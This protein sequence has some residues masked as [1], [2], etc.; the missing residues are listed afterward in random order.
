MTTDSSG[1]RAC[2][3]PILN[4]HSNERHN[5]R[6]REI[7]LLPRA[8]LIEFCEN[9]AVQLLSLFQTGWA[10]VLNV[11]TGSESPVFG[12][13]S[14]DGRSWTCCMTLFSGESLVNILK[15]AS[16]PDAAIETQSAETFNTAVVHKNTE[17]GSNVQLALEVDL[18]GTT[19]S[20]AFS[21][22]TMSNEQAASVAAT[23]AQAIEEIVKN[24]HSKPTELDLFSQHDRNVLSGWNTDIPERLDARVDE[25]IF[26]QGH[27]DP[28]HVAVSSWDGELTYGE[29]ERLSSSLA[30]HLAKQGVRS[31]MF[32]PLCFEKSKWTVVAML[33]VIKAGGAYVLLDPSYP[34]KRMESI[35]QD[36]DATVLVASPQTIDRAEALVDNIVVVDE[37]S[38][39][40]SGNHDWSRQGDSQDALYAAFTSGSTGRPKGIVVEHGAFCTRAL[41]NGAL[42]GL[43]KHSRVL[44]FASYAF[45]VSHR[46]ILF[47]LIH[48]GTVCIPSETDRVNNLEL[49]VNRHQVNW[50]SITPSVAGLL[51]PKAIPTLQTLV[52][53]GEAMTSAHLS[54]WAEKVQLMNAY[55]PSEC[56]AISCINPRLTRGSERTNI[57]RGVGAAIWIVDPEDANRLVPIGAI[58]ELVIETAAVSRGYL[59]NP[60]NTEASF[61]DHVRWRDDFQ[62]SSQ[63]Q[64]YKTGDLGRFNVDGT[65]SFMGRKDSQVKING[66]RVE[67]AEIEHHMLQALAKSLEDSSTIQVVVDMVTPKA[68]HRPTL[69]AFVYQ[70][71]NEQ[72][73]EPQRNTAIRQT[74]AHMAD[75]LAELLPAYMIPSA[76]I[77][78]ERIP[79]TGT[80]KTDRRTLR[81]L[82]ASMTWDQMAS[83][84]ASAPSYR[85]PATEREVQLQRIFMAVLDLEA[86]RVGAD[87]SFL[88]LGGDSIA[89]MRLVAAARREELHLTVADVFRNPRLNEL[90]QLAQTASEPEENIVLP[91][92][93]LKIGISTSD[94][95]REAAS[96][97][98]IQEGQVEDVLPCTPLQEGLLALTA[99]KDSLYI[100]RFKFEIRPTVDIS[101]LMRSWE[102]T[103]AAVPL[104][105]TR[106]AD[107]TGQGLVQVVVNEPVNWQSSPDSQTMG[108]G[109]PLTR[110]E[111]F[112]EQGK[113]YLAL[114]I[115]HAMYDGWSMPLVLDTTQ[116]I[117]RGQQHSLAPFAA[118]IKHIASIDEDAATKFWRRQFV[119]V[120]FSQFPA[121]PL[122][123]ESQADRTLTHSIDINWEGEDFTAATMT[124]AALAI[125][126]SR[127]TNCPD[128]VFG[129]TVMGRHAAVPGVESMA[130]PTFATLP[131]RVIVDEEQTVHQLL[132]QVHTQAT[133][134][135]PY[136]QIGLQHIHRISEESKEACRF[137]TLLL[138]QPG[139]EDISQGSELFFPEEEEQA[140]DTRLGAFTSYALMFRCE[141][142]K[143]GMRLRTTFDSSVVHERQTMRIAHHFAHVLQQICVSAAR[144]TSVS[145]I[146]MATQQDLSD[147]WT[148]NS[149]PPRQV[150]G[151]WDGILPGRLDDHL[152]QLA[153][154]IPWVIQEHAESRLAAVGCVGELWLEIPV[155]GEGH[156][157]KSTASF[158][159]NPHWLLRGGPKQSGRNGRLY[160]SGEL[161]KYT[162]D[163]AVVVLGR[164]DTQPR[165]NGRRVSLRDVEYNVRQ[166]AFEVFHNS[167]VDVIAEI[168]TPQGSQ[169]SMLVAFL[170]NSADLVLT[171]S[172][173]NTIDEELSDRLPVKP[174]AYGILK[175]ETGQINR[176]SFRE[177]VKCFTLAHLTV[178]ERRDQDRARPRTET[179]C[180]LRDLWASV[181]EVPAERIRLNDS[182][183]RLGGDSI[184]AMRLVGAARR[185]GVSLTVEE[186][187][188][189]PQLERLATV[190]KA[191]SAADQAVP[192][193]SLLNLPLNID[194]KRAQTAAL[195]GVESSRVQ[196]AFPCTQLQAGLLALTAQSPGDYIARKVLQLGETTDVNRLTM[197]WAEVVASTPMLR[198]RI[199]DLEN[200]GLVQV[201]VNE[202]F[203]WRTE[204]NL[205][206]YIRADSEEP[207]GLGTPLTR[208]GLVECGMQKYCIL[209]VHHA[210]YDGWLIS[211]LLQAVQKAYHGQPRMA[212]TPFQT[213][214]KA[215]NSVDEASTADFWKS[216]LD[217]LEAPIFPA[218][219]ALSPRTD[220]YATHCIE[221]L[222]VDSG[223]TTVSMAIRAAWAILSAQYVNAT[224]AL[225]GA[226]VTGRQCSVPGIELVGGPTIATVPV[227]VAVDGESTVEQLLQQVQA[228]AVHMIPFEQSGLQR[229][230]RVSADADQAC[231]F[232]TLLVVH[233][234]D[235][236]DQ[237]ETLFIPAQETTGLG[238]VDPYA[239]VLECKLLK[240]GV[241]VQINHDSR[242]IEKGQVER[243]LLQFDHVLRQVCAGHQTTKVRDVGMLSE[244]DLHDIWKWN[245]HIPR[246][247]GV[248]VN[249][250]ITDRTQ[251]QREAPAID[252]WDGRFTYGQLDE[253]STRLAHR[254]RLLGVSTEIFVPLLLEKSR[255]TPVAMLGV[256]KAGG[257]FVL[258]EPNH[259]LTRLQDIC[260][261]VNAH[262]VV[263]SPA[264]AAKAAKLGTTVVT[265]GD[266]QDIG[267]DGG[268]LTTTTTPKNTLY[269]IFTSGS[270]GKPKGAL[271]HHD[272]FASNA[273]AYNEKVGLGSDLRILQFS[274]HAFDVCIS[275][276][277]FT[278]IGGGC[279]CIPSS[280][281]SKDDLSGAIRQFNAN[282]VDLTPSVMR[283]LSPSDV[284]TLTTVSYSGEAASKTDIL[285]WCD[286]VRLINVYGPSE[287]SVFATVQ[288]HITADSDPL[289]IGSPLAGVCWVVNPADSNRLVSV[290]AVGELLLEG[291]PVGKGYL[292]NADK[293]AEAFLDDPSWLVQGYGDQPGRHGR[294]YKTG[295][296]VRYASDGTLQFLGRKDT[297][298]KLRGQRIELGEVEHH[299]DQVLTAI[300]HQ[301]QF[302]EDAAV[303][304][305][306]EIIRPQET[307]RPTLVAFV[308][309]HNSGLP[310]G[311]SIARLDRMVADLDVQ[312]A[313]RLPAYMVPS[314]Y[315]P[316]ESIPL[317]TTGKTDRR[318]LREIG[319]LNHG[320]IA[321]QRQGGKRIAPSTEMESLL[322]EVWMD[323]L[324]LP[325]ETIS[326]D[327]AWIRLGGDSITAM[328]VA[329]RCRARNI[330]L[331]AGD[332]LRAQTIQRLAR[333]C[334]LIQQ[335]APV[336]NTQTIEEEPWGLTPAQHLFFETHPDGLNHFNQ[337]FLLRIKTPVLTDAIRAA[338]HALA[339]R[340]PM[341]RARFQKSRG[342]YWQQYVA[343]YRADV[344]AFAAH[345]VEKAAVASLAQSRQ[346]QLDIQHGPVFA[347]DVFCLPSGEQILLVSAHHLVIDLVSWRVIWHDIE[348][349]LGRRDAVMRPTPSFQAWCKMQSQMAQSLM[350]SQVLPFAVD[351]R[352][353]EYWGVDVAQ[354]IEAES[355]T[356][357]IHLE[358]DVTTRLLGP[359]NERLGTEPT[360][361][362][363]A[364]LFHSFQQ[365]FAD[366]RPPPIFVEGHG[367]E[368]LEGFEVDLSEIV[369][370]F[371]TIFPVYIQPGP[372]DT[373][374]DMIKL[375]KDVR[376]SVPG[377]GLPYTA[378]R[379]LTPAGQTAFGEHRKVE[380][381]FNYVGTY[382][383]LESANSLLSRETDPV[384]TG[385]FS[386]TSPTARRVGLV[387]LNLGTQFGR[388]NI[389]CS[390]HRQMKHQARLQKWMKVFA[391]SL[392]QAA[393]ELTT[394]PKSF[395]LSDFPLLSLSQIGLDSLEKTMQA[396]GISHN[397]VED[398]YPCTPM[399]EGILLSMQKGTASYMT[400]SVR[401]CQ[402]LPGKVPVSP[403]RLE[404]AW[405]DV[406]KRHSILSTVFVPLFENGLF[407]QVLV[408]NAPVRVN[409]ISC[410]SGDPADTLMECAKPVFADGEPQ[411]Q[412]TIC[413]SSNGDVACRL[414]MNHAL[415][416]AESE[417]IIT[418]DLAKAYEGVARSAA[419]R[420]R[421][422]MHHLAHTP[423]ANRMEYW[424][425]ALIN[426]SP[427]R[428]PV[429]RIST[430][431]FPGE[432]G[433]IPL[434]KTATSRIHAFCVNRGI[435]RSVFIQISWAIALSWYTGIDDVC[436]G[437]MAS[438]RDVPIHNIENMV[439]PL[440]NLLISR[441]DVG[442]PLDEVIQKTAESSVEHL[443]HQ[444]VSLAQIQHE[445]KLGHEPLFNSCVTFPVAVNT[446]LEGTATQVTFGYR[447]DL[448]SSSMARDIS[449]MLTMA[450][451]HIL[452][453][454][455]LTNGTS[456][457]FNHVDSL[458]TG[459]F[460]SV[461]GANQQLATDFWQQYFANLDTQHFPSLPSPYYSP[462]ATSTLIYRLLDFQWNR[463]E[464]A[465]STAIRVAWAALLARYTNTSDVVLG[466]LT[467]HGNTNLGTAPV[468][469][470]LDGE[471]TLRQ[472]LEHIQ[473]QTIAMAE[474]ERMGLHNIQRVSDE[475]EQGCQ[476]QTLLVEAACEDG[477]IPNG[478]DAFGLIVQCLSDEEGLHIQAKFD[479]NMIEEAHVERMMRQF[480]HILRQ[481]YAEGNQLVKVKDI[482]W[483]CEEDMRDIW[484][485]NRSVPESVEACM[486]DQIAEMAR[487]QPEALAI[488]AWD[489]ELTYRELD[490]LSTRLA[491]HLMQYVDSDA[492]VPL[493]FEKSVWT[494]VAMI[495][496]MKAGGA[497]LALDTTQPEGRLSTLVEQVHPRLILSSAAYAHMAGQ[498]AKV[499][500]IVVDRAKLDAL[501]ASGPLPVVQPSTT[502]YIIFTSGST[503]KPKGTLISHANFASATLHQRDMLQ[504]GP[505]SRLF[506][507]GSYAFDVAWGNVLH[508]LSS[509]GCLCIPEPAAAK[510][511]ILGSLREYRATHAELTPTLARTLIP[512]DLPDLKCF[513]SSGE[514]M[515][516]LVLQRWSKVTR[517]LNAYGPAECSAI[518]TIAQLTSGVPKGN[519][520]RGLGLNSWIVSPQN[521]NELA[522]VYGVGEL[523]LEGPL[524]GQGYLNQAQKTAE[525]FVDS[526][527]W[528]V[529]GGRHGRLYKT[530]DLVKYHTD[531]SLIFIGRKDT[532]VKIR[533][534]RVEL[535][536]VEHHVRQALG[537]RG[538]AVFT[539]NETI[540][541]VAEAIKPRNG[542]HPVLVAFVSRE[543]Q[544]QSNK[545]VREIT[546][547]LDEK[548][549]KF[550]PAYMIPTAYIPIEQL[551]LTASGKA[552]RLKLQQHASALTR[553]DLAL[554]TAG[555]QERRAP[556]TKKETVLQRLCA[557]VLG[558]G[559]D[560]IGL[561]DSFF[562]LGGDSIAAIKLVAM[563][564]LEGWNITVASIFSH[565]KLSDLALT[566]G[567]LRADADRPPPPFSLLP[568]GSAD[569][570]RDTLRQLGIDDSAV[571]DVYPCTALQEG[572]IAMTVKNPDTYVYQ[573]AYALPVDVDSDAFR[574]AWD[575]T[576]AANPILRTRLIHTESGMFQA[577]V[578][579]SIEWE[580]ATSMEDYLADDTHGRMDLGV[581]LLRLA[582]VREDNMALS[583]VLTIHHALYDGFSLPLILQQVQESY[584]GNALQLRPFS[585]FMA[586]LSQVDKK[587]ER[588]FWV[589]RF[590]NLRAP[591]FPALPSATYTPGARMSFTQSI[592]L[593]PRVGRDF[594]LPT[595][596]RLAWAV[597]IAHHTD[598]DDVVFGETLTGRNASF[599]NVDRLTGPTIT[600]IP[601]RVELRAGQSLAEA[602]DAVQKNMV[603]AIP[604]EQA[605]LQNIRQMSSETAAACEFQSHL[606]IQP[607]E[608]DLEESTLFGQHQSRNS[609][610][611][612]AS[613]AFVLVCSL[614]SN[615][616]K[617]GVECNFDS[618][619]VD[620]DE[621]RKHVRLFETILCQICS[622]PE[623]QISDL[624]VISPAD[625]AQL[626]KWNS[627]LP[628]A[629]Y[630][631]LHD[632]ILSHCMSQPDRA[633]IS[634]WDGTVTYAELDVLSRALAL[635]L[636]S[637]GVESN[638]IVPLCFQRSKWSVISIMAVLR[639]G[640]A[641]LL[642][643]PT[644]PPER[645]QDFMEQTRAVTAVVDPFQ[646]ALM[647]GMVP[648]VI[649]VSSALID[650]LD[651]SQTGPLPTVSPGN[652]AF[653]VFTSG[654]TGKPKGIILEH[655]QLST[656]I[657]DHGPGMGVNSDSRSLH[658]ASYA[659]DAS[660]YEICS[661]L[662]SGGCVCI[663]S[664]HDR[665]NDLAAFIRSQKVTW[666]TLPNSA[667][668]ILHPDDVPSLQT[669]V[670]GG[671]AVTQDV[672]EKWASRLTLINGYGPAEATICAVG[673]IPV[674]GWKPGT[675]GNIVGGV[676]WIATPS[677]A[678]KLAAIGAVGELLIEGPVLAR[679]Y[680]NNPEK[681]A[682]SF[683][684]DLPWMKDFRPAGKGRVYKSGDLV[685][686]NPD[687][688]FRFIGRK[689]TQVKLR[690]Q[691][692]E[693][694]E[695]EFRIRQCLPAVHNVVAEVIIP[696]GSN[697]N[698]LLVAFVHLPMTSDDCKNLFLTPTE[699]LR[700]IFFAAQTKLRGMVPAYMVPGLFI[701]LSHIPR[702]TSGKIDRRQLRDRASS[703]PRTDFN[704]FMAT[705]GEIEKPYTEMEERLQ[706][707]LISVTD[708]SID[709]IGIKDNIFHLGA[710]SITIMKMVTAARKQGI[711]ISV[712]DVFS[713][714][715][716]HDLAGFYNTNHPQ[717]QAV[718]TVVPGSVFGF[719]NQRSFIDSINCT[720]LPFSTPDIY[721]A[722]PA[723]QGQED[724]LLRGSYYFM[725]DFDHPIDRDRLEKACHGLVQRH[726]IFRTV[727]IPYQGRIAQI[728]LRSSN[729]PIEIVKSDDSLVPFTESLCQKD[730]REAPMLGDLI[731]RMTLV[732]GPEHRTTLILRISHAQYDGMSMSIIW[733]DLA[734]L[735]EGMQLPDPI[736]YSTHVQK[737]L[738][739][740]TSQAYE[741]WRNLLDASS[742]TYIKHKHLAEKD[743]SVSSPIYVESIIALPD[744]PHGITMATLIKAAWSLVL[745][746]LT[747]DRDVVFGQTISGR[748][749]SDFAAENLVG[750]CIN[751]IPVRVKYNPH[752]TLLDLLRHV[753]NQHGESL[754]F[755]SVELRDI[756][757]RSTPWPQGTRFGSVV[758]HQ[759]IDVDKPFSVGGTQ[760]SMRMFHQDKPRSYVSISTSPRGQE[761]LIELGA[762]NQTLSEPHAQRVAQCLGEMIISIACGP[763]RHISELI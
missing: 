101:Q 653:I 482:P 301:K 715:T 199:V 396:A 629:R 455:R 711:L 267:C 625:I 136:E 100:R 358:E 748:S 664:E 657:R 727:F 212:L 475:A 66:Q 387:E 432:H 558:V 491:S 567:V 499:P 284:P 113:T 586:Y 490:T 659:F 177:Q 689:D 444:H 266:G 500:V 461:V 291:P 56:I 98:G 368:A 221:A 761:L 565:P 536:E 658:F 674:Q 647:Q 292:N 627:D 42:L 507:V 165:L 725:L 477:A 178:V 196:D 359:S 547:G 452:Q 515:D 395:T 614:S 687:G 366:R 214:V 195:C 224:E 237:E 667:T 582:L 656:S 322:L 194:E 597:V 289:N 296:L 573:T 732:Q 423:A 479:S 231:Q 360:E 623:Q 513:I 602:L 55:G 485:W 675:F 286:S 630:E 704:L 740:G 523:W 324:N 33:G 651:K 276:I 175:D 217:G 105:R 529:D 488:C 31:E 34:P 41:A 751:A 624:Q 462:H 620:E 716:I 583:F 484:A 528:L 626:V 258:L 503:G 29:L 684:E 357:V 535:A 382:Q 509:G 277:L 68:S 384:V 581:P 70:T 353:Y 639:T 533:G 91:F 603:A 363:L 154:H 371:T 661:T 376:R 514:A 112:T 489:G 596:I 576:V 240:Q 693:L 654:S 549:A 433:Y 152:T 729:A 421:D 247:Q 698:S 349:L 169:S 458:R 559:I 64:L 373:I 238:S 516:D 95:R 741:F 361:I 436:F 508:T 571:E 78:V 487:K 146:E 669:L 116:K 35:C 336:L 731:T 185:H 4:A 419:P 6:H 350:P 498:I 632:L 441:V 495:A 749:S 348:Q 427:C 216:Q 470:V 331:T 617:I 511:D 605:G 325:A 463:A 256:I 493:C 636:I 191:T 670:L 640:A 7:D 117:Y 713:H 160:K 743:A 720:G 131:V 344:V 712:T 706:A 562:R 760:P 313:E 437:Y 734:D 125:L 219:S 283:I 269:A 204:S 634:S 145:Q 645:I 703:L 251:K 45:D 281:Q 616:Q 534:Q 435:T 695:V 600:T 587:A 245:A 265:V 62:L 252:A 229:I 521:D 294:L 702:T 595:L 550:L 120:E 102:Q 722:L 226:T 525:V 288:A 297:Q 726:T 143:Q 18:D 615:N 448:I 671:E 323:V 389:S 383:Q 655:V 330:R 718:S 20:L 89:A 109:T 714:P 434:V 243:L 510:D 545:T 420:F 362:L 402:M 649:T 415:N 280:S 443:A 262:I 400:Y 572:L 719:T 318:R 308:S 43:N 142:K 257:A 21:S 758:T 96:L 295:D 274:S 246:A 334:S 5:M 128:A 526:P 287:C 138:V 122:S 705:R 302:N 735:Y 619:I 369:G 97:C 187:F 397:A 144:D 57:G 236:D 14:G 553:E 574:A 121:L 49:F 699:E 701:P 37:S 279:I 685:Q 15:T 650:G 40:W 58:G 683:I 147:I 11:Y 543:S 757:A 27:Q 496:V 745:T 317:S 502:L 150:D 707:I 285:A 631:T 700:A 633:A 442:Q 609:S 223:D 585:P 411:H 17:T 506:D 263:S 197:A 460:Q 328:Q 464:V 305:V 300:C 119:G 309:I 170:C 130:G 754:P 304:V 155:N 347:A 127:Y 480:E 728:V 341:L 380:V 560:I 320:K 474:F 209:T 660:I 3:F 218:V 75:Q 201:E 594:T 512:D 673:P 30:G 205:D 26:H 746:Q 393:H 356:H 410:K 399:Q 708:L 164:K 346:E 307:G 303:E 557:G 88:R 339:E 468:R 85:A 608:E 65:I 200:Q 106:I 638:M 398:I 527:S 354:N 355:E 504:L 644:H 408:A 575:A 210:M 628:L 72:K 539:S 424:R 255:W 431:V 94:A 742:M 123:H 531:G 93:L 157:Y 190:S 494:A 181:L 476:F 74:T 54:T 646:T 686:Y 394:G 367:R 332:V 372:S 618:S 148:W 697:A 537:Q 409:Q 268:K 370:W 140:G 149:A 652:T 345:H 483:A 83:L 381:L 133:D 158:A 577:V 677:D 426:V 648:N 584:M 189:Y 316:L 418:N 622:D 293:T 25:M 417:S 16:L 114:T 79:M 364:M 391:D 456:E 86:D 141:L 335:D 691:R 524:V 172:I 139:E 52:L 759:N 188:S 82:G 13:Q 28:S 518:S 676:G 407:A 588:D 750:L 278:L 110:H 46:D 67:L 156:L 709:E 220:S 315:F 135:I 439:G 453:S 469:M 186:I 47:T 50:A 153:G 337:S 234:V 762:S 723:S 321:A 375:A 637:T 570:V 564:R 447:K 228:Q 747:G 377:K 107:L 388:L 379:H 38:P 179:E 60:E 59:K 171:S 465:G 77:P 556:R 211:L 517:I 607:L 530:G 454:E 680:L 486:H 522:P 662:V 755:E 314:T 665:M 611:Q 405:K 173:A 430:G 724:R 392:T 215:I 329:S 473:G 241:R 752:W 519:I 403:A 561:D 342:G 592:T 555:E 739:A 696:S 604:Y 472:L 311:E 118:F 668:N 161:A 621:A 248:C 635:H 520:G 129:V 92:S 663:M 428:F 505:G 8:A 406:V 132:Q 690:G 32:V 404:A 44:Q 579:G 548:L 225:F 244:A 319:S 180:Q 721:D 167:S 551:P 497:S 736:E 162:F 569:H 682:S 61:P 738:A 306:A 108:L 744:P 2:L 610:D 222:C 591:I 264:Q 282:L 478:I 202:E 471:A 51:D 333:S 390:L 612:F 466:V 73:S 717:Y 730:S 271:V 233:P 481:F 310:V 63:G 679:G 174:D 541:I 213:F 450:I 501:E 681:T 589:S 159:E 413:Q 641:C 254:L 414:D 446:L 22:S 459:F 134:M 1:E 542:S 239:L 115:H 590:S 445:L 554:L 378:S 326:V 81:Q 429:Q 193:F 538:D 580:T 374:V 260:A 351:T 451:E 12:C 99:R 763:H 412:L 76:C 270:T 24:P 10:L 598:S 385:N 672:V 422:L 208:F 457:R 203:S 23:F 242:V 253:L 124:R 299:V 568:D 643:D 80:G 386:Q 87:D 416:D 733:R 688:T 184:T 338:I 401:R 467:K 69:V 340:H 192:P 546:A 163:G 544:D 104:L 53:A 235:S 261:E 39:I 249:D 606:G 90:A 578:R 272:G 666:A 678:S 183:F 168:V 103:V 137:Q 552:D 36:I 566:M 275:D 290:G 352:G 599:A 166:A 613:Y 492:T 227:R 19:D 259:P 753:Q 273:V 9:H 198:T 48:N 327:S 694:G 601:I 532:Q 126:I 343:R 540:H 593:P 312:L 692:I 642:V 111:I 710:D 563:A 250:L 425:K 438:G 151:S 298:V 206:R 182:F 207:M 440:A 84:T 230:R 737:W 756:V 176:N 365:V 232:Q 71:D 449:F